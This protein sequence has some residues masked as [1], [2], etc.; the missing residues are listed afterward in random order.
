MTILL[1][2][3]A[4]HIAGPS[5]KCVLWQISANEVSAVVSG[6]LLSML[7]SRGWWSWARCARPLAAASVPQGRTS[8]SLHRRDL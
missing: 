6:L 3:I 7:S 2:D 5:H 8:Q 4:I 1:I